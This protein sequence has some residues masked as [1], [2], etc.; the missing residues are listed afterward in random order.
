[1]KNIFLNITFMMISVFGFA[2]ET[3]YGT[4]LTLAKLN[5]KEISER[6]FYLTLDKEKLSISGKSG[7]NN[8]NVSFQAKSNKTCIKTGQGMGTMMA[9]DET[10]MKLE[11]EFLTTIQNKKFK[12][13]TKGDKVY[14][15]NWWGKTIMEFEKQTEKSV[16]NYIGEN[17]WKLIQMNNV[18]KDYEKA[19]IKFDTTENRVSG[20]AGCNSFFGSYKVD[21]EYI[22][23]T[24]MGATKMLCD[25]ESNETENEFF[26]ILS[27]KKLRYDL[28][29]QTL[30]L[31]DGNR[32]VMMFGVVK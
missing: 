20:N 27:G 6:N 15:K 7:C 30:N 2:N 21:G 12:I 32:L 24:Q 18:G 10:V 22:S 28:A 1:M 19:S 11:Q 9:C 3:P 16:W 25:E 4:K 29:D 23:F 14:F 31:Y 13:K 8:F 17:R 5:G 26:K